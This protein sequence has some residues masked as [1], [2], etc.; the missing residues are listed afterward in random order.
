M[1]VFLDVDPRELRAPSLAG[2]DPFKL[3]RQVARYG[4][5][6]SGMPPIAVYKYSDGTLIVFDGLTRATRIAKLSRGTFGA[7]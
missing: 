5:S 4:A 7:C 2:A 3:H 1:P 6:T